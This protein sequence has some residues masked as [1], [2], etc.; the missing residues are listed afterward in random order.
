MDALKYFSNASDNM[1]KGLPLEV[2]AL[3]LKSGLEALG[4]IIGETS[5]EEILDRIFSEF[6]LGK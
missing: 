5:N 3:D 2:I 4:E 1:R 6:C